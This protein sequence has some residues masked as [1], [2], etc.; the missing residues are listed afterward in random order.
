M[1]ARDEEVGV[2][3]HPEVLGRLD[4]RRVRIIHAHQ[5]LAPPPRQVI[6]EDLVVVGQRRLAGD[7]LVEAGRGVVV[8]RD[9]RGGDALAGVPVPVRRI[10]RGVR[11][12]RSEVEEEGSAFGLR[13]ADL[14][15][16]QPLDALIADQSCGI[17]RPTMYTSKAVCGQGML[18]VLGAQSVGF[19]W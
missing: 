8:V 2:L 17:C 1:V 13:A 6:D 10:C 5:A 3:V 11:A 4:N 9:P 16:V 7:Q 19:P 15:A 14:R 18:S 12:V